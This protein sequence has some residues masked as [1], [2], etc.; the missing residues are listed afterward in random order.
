M[1][2]HWEDYNLLGYEQVRPDYLVAENIV[3]VLDHD[4][5][6]ETILP[7][8]VMRLTN[9]LQPYCNRADTH[10]YTMDKTTS[11]DRRKPPKQA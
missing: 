10:W 4:L 6:L 8:V 1:A 7:P 3:E 11:P 2:D 5:L 9:V